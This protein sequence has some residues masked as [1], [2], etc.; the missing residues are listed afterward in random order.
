MSVEDGQCY[1][2]IIPEFIREYHT[3]Y[4]NILLNCVLSHH[5]IMAV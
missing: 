1:I 2:K 4:L 3:A 5:S